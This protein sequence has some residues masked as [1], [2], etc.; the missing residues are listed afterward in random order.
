MSD[1]EENQGMQRVDGGT[2]LMARPVYPE[3]APTTAVGSAP[4]PFWIDETP[5][6]QPR[7]PA[8]VASTGHVTLAERPDP[9]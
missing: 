2:Y 1:V 3:E 5:V 4:D 8:F 9:A 7:M 6:T